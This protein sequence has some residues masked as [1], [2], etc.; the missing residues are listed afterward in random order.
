MSIAQTLPLSASGKPPSPRGSGLLSG[1]A[2]GVLVCNI[3]VVLWGAVVRATGSGAGCGDHWPLCNGVLV[4]AHPRVATLIELAHRLTSG[5]A[6]IGVVV[7]L[8][9]TFRSTVPRHL[10]RI[11]SVAATVLIFNE[12][13][14]G[15]LIVLLGL[16]ANNRSGARAVYLSLHFANT[17][18]LLG[19]LAL[20]AHFTSRKPALLRGS[21]RLA[22]APLALLG[23]GATLAVG[24]S[25]SL[26]ALGDTL[27]PSRSLM[28]ALAQDLSAQSS[29][30]LR[31]RFLHPVAAIVAGIF[32][33]WLIVRGFS[34]GS[35]LADRRLGVSVLI[36][37]ALQYAMGV[38]DVALL[39]PLWLQILHLLGADLLWVTLV[40]LTAR[41]FLQVSPAAQRTAR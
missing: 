8:V 11:T 15:A 32:I 3:A 2:W 17:F 7:L 35:A 26:A 41:I 18:L 25:G 6:V 14:L 24:V 34:R 36:L 38:A 13:L 9:W 12:A 31:L 29:W 30:L 28:T 4:Q 40:V 27:F 33:C 5:I 19:A 16:T 37:L 39:A 23:L 20:S 1:F 22:Q 21:V 10:A